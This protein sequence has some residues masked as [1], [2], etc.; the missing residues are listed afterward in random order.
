LSSHCIAYAS[1]LA[2]LWGIEGYCRFCVAPA[3]DFLGWVRSSY[4]G[5]VEWVSVQF[6]TPYKFEVPAVASGSSVGSKRKTSGGKNSQLPCSLKD[7]KVCDDEGGF[8]VTRGLIDQCVDIA[9][10]KGNEDGRCGIYVQSNVEDVAVTLR[11]RYEESLSLFN[12]QIIK[13]DNATKTIK[14]VN[15]GNNGS[16]C[17][18][19]MKEFDAK[20][21][22]QGNAF[23]Y[24][25]FNEDYREGEM[26]AEQLYGEQGDVAATLGQDGADNVPR[27][28]QQWIASGGQRADPSGNIPLTNCV[29]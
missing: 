29:F 21:T 22:S 8:M 19:Y 7:G 28:Q 4:P 14:T 11:A 9:L 13:N 25:V 10:N 23:P 3:E 2:H 15:D 12:I 1:G 24:D 16:A 6:P 5:P 27:R 18:Y 26:V 17:A 20:N